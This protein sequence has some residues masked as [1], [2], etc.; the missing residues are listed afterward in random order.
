MISASISRFSVTG[1][2]LRVEAGSLEG[3]VPGPARHDRQQARKRLLLADDLPSI[4][5]SLS[6]LLR[7]QGYH[8]ELA[9]NGREAI[10][11]AA[12][13][14]FDLVLLDLSM[15]ELNG[16]EALQRIVAI[17]PDLPVVIITALPHQQ[18]WVEPAGAMALLEKPLDIPLLLSTINDFTENAAATRRQVR[19]KNFPSKATANSSGLLS[20]SGIN[21]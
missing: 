17:K 2:P 14:P 9:E 4:R 7:G 19:F 5:D 13:E 1:Q 6:R 8:V 3:T 16:W 11:R 20:R 21:E 18:K 10:E 12:A 15:P